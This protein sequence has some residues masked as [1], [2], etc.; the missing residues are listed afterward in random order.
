MI[1]FQTT[2]IAKCNDNWTKAGRRGEKREKECHLEA[3]LAEKPLVLAELVTL[4]QLVL[5]LLPSLLSEGGIAEAILVDERLVHDH[6]DR[7]PRRHHVVEVDHLD[8]RL[9]LAA[10]GHLLLAHLLRHLQ[11]V[12]VDA[13]DEGVSVGLVRATFIVVLDNDGFAAGE[14]AVQH[15]HHLALLQEFTHLSRIKVSRELP[16]PLNIKRLFGLFLPKKII[17]NKL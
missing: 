2:Y 11:G 7:I 6:V 14:A 8:E 3:E 9:D 17:L 4:L 5:D 12:P 16:V 13:G 1:G 10:L 15:Q